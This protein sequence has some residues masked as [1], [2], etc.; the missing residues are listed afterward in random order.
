MLN[1][2]M[3]KG[4]QADSGIEVERYS[5]QNSGVF[6]KI[7]TVLIDEEFHSFYQRQ[8]TPNSL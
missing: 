5:S 3:K 1:G 6:Y 8:I 7:L 2:V 4:F